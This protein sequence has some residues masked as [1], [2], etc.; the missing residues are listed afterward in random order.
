MR[1][2]G[3]HLEGGPPQDSFQKG[4]VSSII[5][6]V[7]CTLVE[8]VYQLGVKCLHKYVLL[9]YAFKK[10]HILAKTLENFYEDLHIHKG[11]GWAPKQQTFH[12]KNNAVK[13]NQK[14]LVNIVSLLLISCTDTD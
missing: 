10:C 11:T 4:E 13:R 12:W 6:H 9:N 8:T 7:E 2:T 3:C 14:H 5:K 1:L